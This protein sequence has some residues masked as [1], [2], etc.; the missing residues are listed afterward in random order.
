MT[1]TALL[2]MGFTQEV[3]DFI[4]W[5]ARYQLPDGRIPCCVDR[6]GA[7]PRAR[8]RQQRRVHL[9][10]RRV[11]PLHARHRLRVR[12][13]AGGRARRARHRRAAPT[14][15][16]RRLQAAG[17]ARVLRPAARVDQPRGLLGAPGALVLGRL[18]RAARAQGRGEPRRRRRRRGA[19]VQLR[20]AARRL[21]PRPVRLDRPRHG[22]SITSTSFPARPSSA[23]STRPRPRSR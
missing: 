9:R 23:T 11:L 2:E 13:V 6:R 18:L 5:F 21:P 19:R 7:D 8:A 3:R 20:G 16:D 17:Q 10:D 4:R 12:A 14:A 15:H 22:G 1:S